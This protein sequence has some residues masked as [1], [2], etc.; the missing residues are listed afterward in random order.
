MEKLPIII[1]RSNTW[2]EINKVNA[3]T[4]L[5]LEIRG[6]DQLWQTEYGYVYA[7]LPKN[8]LT[9]HIETLN[10]FY[11]AI[12]CE[13]LS[14]ACQTPT[15]VILGNEFRIGT[16]FNPEFTS[17]L[18]KMPD[19]IYSISLEAKFQDFALRVFICDTDSNSGSILVSQ[20]NCSISL[21][22]RAYWFGYNGQIN[23][24]VLTAIGPVSPGPFFTEIK[25]AYKNL[26]KEQIEQFPVTKKIKEINLESLNQ[27]FN[28]HLDRLCLSFPDKREELDKRKEFIVNCIKF[29][30]EKISEFICD[31]L[32]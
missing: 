32:K 22:D 29:R 31:L 9:A 5:N 24:I 28:E 10:E 17:T 4:S 11:G 19:R 3:K 8:S 2:K 30:K 6:N 26:T 1:N 27:K 13:T 15:G 23:E 25:T 7:K 14:I 16:S 18:E 21:I 20:T 12:I